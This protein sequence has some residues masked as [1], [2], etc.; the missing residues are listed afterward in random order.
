MLQKLPSKIHLKMIRSMKTYELYNKL[1][2]EK[3]MKLINIKNKSKVKID[4]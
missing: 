1:Q 4:R 3:M 2:I